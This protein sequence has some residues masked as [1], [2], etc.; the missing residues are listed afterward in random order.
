[1]NAALKRRKNHPRMW[2]S[3]H[4]SGSRAAPFGLNRIAARAGLKVSELNAEINV[5][6]AIVNA[7][8]RKN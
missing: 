1:L 7:N 8:C 2:S 4:V 5:D 6:V 3:S